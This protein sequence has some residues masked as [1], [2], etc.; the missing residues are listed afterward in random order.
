[1]AAFFRDVMGMLPIRDEPE[2]VGFQMTDGT[3]VELYRLKEEFHY[4]FHL[5]WLLHSSEHT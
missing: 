2:I 5:S 1:M 4:V 3:H